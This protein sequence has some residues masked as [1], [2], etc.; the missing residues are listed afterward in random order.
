TFRTIKA[1][2]YRVALDFI[3]TYYNDARM[4]G[5]T[6]DRHAEEKAV[7]L[8][9]TNIMV[10]GESFLANPMDTP[11]IPSWNRVISAMPDVLDRLYE[12]VEADNSE[13]N[14]G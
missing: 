8:F 3:E 11:F 5:L 9:A 1:T 4:N 13:M 10:A 2:Y 7:E 6:L 14:Q 12:A